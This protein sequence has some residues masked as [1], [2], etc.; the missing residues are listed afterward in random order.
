MLEPNTTAK[1]E[2]NLIDPEKLARLL[3]LELKQKR[4]EW[5]ETAARHR[6]MRT[7]SYLF[8]FVLIAGCAIALVFL[9]SKA[10]EERANRPPAPPTSAPGR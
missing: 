5:K 8:F 7:N 2:S 6:R 4:A 3:D 1:P 10:S 9:F